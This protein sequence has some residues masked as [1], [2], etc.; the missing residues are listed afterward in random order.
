V[1][2]KKNKISLSGVLVETVTSKVIKEQG[3]IMSPLI[4][5]SIINTDSDQ[6]K[7]FKASA[8]ASDTKC[9]YYKAR[10]KKLA[11]K[12]VGM[13]FGDWTAS[14]TKFYDDYSTGN[15]P[16]SDTMNEWVEWVENK[17]PGLCH[18][19]HHCVLPVLEVAAFALSGP[20]GW[21]VALGVSMV[22]GSIDAAMYYK[23]GDKEVAGLVLFLTV[24]PGIPSVVKKF[25]FV[26]EWGE[27]GAKKIAGR[28]IA[29]ESISKLEQYQLKALSTETAQAYIKKEAVK[30]RIRK[31][32][33]LGVREEVIEGI[34]KYTPVQ[35]QF[36]IKFVKE[37]APYVAAAVSY[38]KI[39]DAVAKT[40]VMGPKD[41]IRKSWGREP[42]DK[43]KII[44]SRFF[45]RLVNQEVELPDYET[46]WD[47]IK[48]M[49]NSSGS[50]EDNELMV[51][52]IKSGWNPFELG[53]GVVPKP[54][55]TTGYKEWVDNVLGNQDVIDWFR[56]DG[57]KKDTNLLLSW[58]F[59]NK[60][61]DPG[62]PGATAIP[63]E[64]RTEDYKIWFDTA[65]EVDMDNPYLLPPE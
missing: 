34:L 22:I 46:E 7:E 17:E 8:D 1:V 15:Q 47:F 37:A 62:A 50:A 11:R 3:F 64:Y 44:S 49:F 60:D 13:E 35:Q 5:G 31:A 12:I 40:G 57:S 28:I 23:E 58:V 48:V 33:P 18:K 30:E 14:D 53:S 36:L 54:F 61:Y 52:A 41:L 26:K 42:D 39:Y 20:F 27:A 16:C 59:D 45:A 9:K 51:K 38:I 4:A 29:E 10:A 43:A 65:T 56:S 55:R 32:I 2:T 21:G 24:L 25:P 63:E 19:W 6:Y